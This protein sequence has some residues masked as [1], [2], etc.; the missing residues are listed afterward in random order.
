VLRVGVDATILQARV[1][2]NRATSGKADACLCTDLRVWAA[3]LRQPDKVATVV[4]NY[5]A[6]P[7]GTQRVEVVFDGLDPMEVPVTA[8][9]DASIRTADPVRTNPRFWQLQRSDPPTGWQAA[10][11]PTPVPN[12]AQLERYTATVDM[13]R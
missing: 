8:A 5:P 9:S 6:L 7:K 1:V 11:W 3:V 10:E 4:T 12:S 13:I 2:T